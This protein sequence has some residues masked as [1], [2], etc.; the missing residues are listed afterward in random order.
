M[1]AAAAIWTAFFFIAAAISPHPP[2]GT[3]GDGPALKLPALIPALKS[4]GYR[5]LPVNF[6]GKAATFCLLYALPLILLGAGPWVVSPAAKIFGWAFA[7]W[8]TYLYWW[9]GILY[10]R[11]TRRSIADAHPGAPGASD[12][13]GIQ[14]RS[15]D[16]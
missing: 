14:R 12:T 9:A 10:L 4:R 16:D 2:I 11:Q 3:A 6:I 5:S 8:G 1:F 15:M 13:L 7:L